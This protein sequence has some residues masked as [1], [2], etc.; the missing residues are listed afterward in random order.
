MF[1]ELTLLLFYLSSKRYDVCIFG[2]VKFDY[3]SNRP[4]MANG[5][6]VNFCQ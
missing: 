5:A 6:I 3:K 1:L 2:E 4:T